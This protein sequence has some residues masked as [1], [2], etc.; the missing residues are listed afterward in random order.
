MELEKALQGLILS[1]I[2]VGKSPHNIKVYQYVC[3]KS[4]RT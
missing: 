3:D 1:K 2:V 4:F